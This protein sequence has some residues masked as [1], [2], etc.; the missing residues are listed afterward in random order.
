MRVPVRRRVL[1]RFAQLDRMN[2]AVHNKYLR[3]M[4]L[5]GLGR[6]SPEDE[7]RYKQ[8]KSY[9]KTERKR[10]KAETKGKKAFKAAVRAAGVSMKDWRTSK[11][12]FKQEI[13]LGIPSG[14]LGPGSPVQPPWMPGIIDVPPASTGS[15]GGG[16]G[17]GSGAPPMDYGDGEAAAGGAPA[18]GGSILPLAL[19]AAGIYF[20]T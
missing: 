2:A 3:P 5:N 6:M 11:K 20:L 9:Y 8:L 14:P 1:P 18:K 12:A 13:K 4:Q 19:A 15:G 17:G 10:L 16:G 7:A